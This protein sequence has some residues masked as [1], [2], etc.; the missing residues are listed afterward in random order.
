LGQ[1]QVVADRARRAAASIERFDP[2]G[3]GASTWRNAPSPDSLGTFDEVVAHEAI[4]N[5]SRA[6][7][8]DGHFARAVEEAFKCLNGAVKRRSGEPRRDGSDL[9]FHVFDADAPVLRL[10]RLRSVSDVDEQNGYRLILAGAMKGMRNPR[11]HEH[12]LQDDPD[13]ALEM[14]VLAS[15]LM[16]MLDRSKRTK[17]K[18]S[19]PRI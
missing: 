10:N 4:R 18:R 1:G 6:L 8:A 16:R 17:V 19:V 3:R 9:M 14:I 15:H 2:G 7:F 11:A 5:S 13:G 12:Q